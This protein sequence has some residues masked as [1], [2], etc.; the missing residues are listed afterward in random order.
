[1]HCLA[2]VLFAIT[3]ILKLFQIIL[4]DTFMNALYMSAGTQINSLPLQFHSKYVANLWYTTCFSYCTQRLYLLCPN[5]NSF[6][7]YFILAPEIFLPQFSVSFLNY[8]SVDIQQNLLFKYLNTNMK[9]SFLLCLPLRL[10]P[11][12]T[13]AL[14]Y[15]FGINKLCFLSLDAIVNYFFQ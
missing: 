5:S 13:S 11:S 12:M 3:P 9:I 8:T 6:L 14:L 4:L 15:L 7:V 1:M 2:R 10:L